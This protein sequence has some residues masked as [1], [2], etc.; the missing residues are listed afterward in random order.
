MVDR[1]KELVDVI[2]GEREQLVIVR[3]GRVAQV[4]QA[5]PSPTCMQNTAAAAVLQCPNREPG[6]QYTSRDRN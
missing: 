4:P 3:V 1:T 5:Q 6:L 2:L